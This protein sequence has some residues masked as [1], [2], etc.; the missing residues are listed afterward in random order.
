MT[1]YDIIK[2]VV[3]NDIKTFKTYIEDRKIF[4]KYKWNTAYLVA[5]GEGNAQ[6]MKI[7]EDNYGGALE[8]EV[9]DFI[10][11]AMV[12]NFNDSYLKKLG[13]KSNNMGNNNNVLERTFDVMRDNDD[14]LSKCVVITTETNIDT[15]KLIRRYFEKELLSDSDILYRAAKAENELLFRYILNIMP[16]EEVSTK[17][18]ST[19]SKI[20]RN[21]LAK[22]VIKK[23]APISTKKLKLSKLDTELIVYIIKHKFYKKDEVNN[24]VSEIAKNGTIY[25]LEYVLDKIGYP[26]SELGEE[27]IPR[28]NARII[29]K[30]LNEN[31]EF[32]ANVK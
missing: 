32:M 21:D 19:L 1:E 30:Y 29:V 31:G 26:H 22:R 24:V 11:Q 3:E 18:I 14:D 13:L 15:Y 4:K 17:L 10:F 8:Y 28:K 16:K 25:E 6:I 20:K 23:L 2:S 5:V 9:C 12:G 27:D 7:I